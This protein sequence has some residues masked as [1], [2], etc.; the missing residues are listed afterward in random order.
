MGAMTANGL[1]EGDTF[2]YNQERVTIERV[3]EP[4]EWLDSG[5]VFF[6]YETDEYCGCID[7]KIARDAI[8]TLV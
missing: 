4:R 7:G 1:K 6:H 3:L 5:T 8:V 2:M